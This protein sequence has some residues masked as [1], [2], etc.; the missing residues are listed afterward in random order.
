MRW[1]AGYPEPHEFKSVYSGVMIQAWDSTEMR[2]T[3]VTPLILTISLLSAPTWAVTVVQ[4]KDKSG[5]VTF[6][7]RCPPEADQIAEQ[8]LAGAARTN[9]DTKLAE[10]MQRNPVQLFSMPNCD[11]C[12]LVRHQLQARKIQFAEHLVDT[13]AAQQNALK[14]LAGSLTVPA[15]AIGKQ[16]VTGYNRSALDSALKQAGYPLPAESS[17]GTAAKP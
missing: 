10:V 9:A 15:V 5:S 4:C 13:D 17:A 11:A 14:T 6:R 16:V 3:V 8:K 1:R 7:D 12:D 2:I